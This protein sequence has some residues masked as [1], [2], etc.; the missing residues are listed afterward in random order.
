MMFRM[1]PS[2]TLVEQ[3]KNGTVPDSEV[4]RAVARVLT[5]KFRLGLFDH[6]YVD[7]DYAEKINN[8]PEHKKLAA[9]TARKAI[10]LLKN[11]KGLLPLDST[12][13]KSIA[14]IG[15][16]AADV[17]LGG[18]SRDPGDGVSVLSGIK[19]KVGNKVK[20]LYA[21]GCKITTAPQGFRGWW[22][23]DVQLV[24][25]KTQTAPIQAAVDAARK[26]D[27]SILV[28]G[29]NESTNR[30]AWAE[31]HRGDRDSLDLLGAQNDLV[32]AVVEIGKPVVV[33]LLNGR[34][35]SINYIAENVPAILEG[36][37]LGEEGGTAAA[38]VIFGD[39]TPAE[40]YP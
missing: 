21:E 34:P 37:Y 17:H 14:V 9:E 31:N 3:V 19:A 10:V 4:D 6:P 24:D 1:R 22:A 11:D 36:F 25:P 12:K 40:S 15:P 33:L 35:V 38:D 32:K 7:P 23:N 30:E 26:A 2:I 29:E 18:Y 28:V 27:V 39:A 8:S 16:N 20:V 5:T 13:L